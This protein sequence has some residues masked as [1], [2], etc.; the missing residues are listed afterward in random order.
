MFFRA[1]LRLTAWY[2]G[3]I[4]VVLVVLGGAAYL[5]LRHELDAEIHQSL[6]DATALVQAS[7]PTAPSDSVVLSG[8]DDDSADRHEGRNGDDDH[9]REAGARQLPTDV[10]TIWLN[11][12]GSVVSNPRQIDT[13]GFPLAELAATALESP[14]EDLRVGDVHYR[15]H[16]S[17]ASVTRDSV[18]V[19]GRSLA[20]RDRQLRALTLVL[21]L[22]GVGAVLL[23]G[24]GG[25]WIAGR[26]LSPIRNALETQR[27]FVS[28]ASH[29]LRTPVAVVRAN[30]EV[31]LR[32]PDENIE[33]NI[34]H[35][36]AI[37]DES[38]HMSRLVA[39][40][41]TLARADEERLELA[42]E[43]VELDV[44]LAAVT[45]DMSA[46]A[47][48]RGV[49]LE[50]SLHSAQ[51]VGDRQRLRQVAAILI[52]NAIKYTP[53]G[54]KVT[55]ACRRDG[56]RVEFTVTDT[57][58]GIAPEDRRHIFERFYRADRARTGGSGSGLGLAIAK[59]IVDAHDGQI[60]VD[61]LPGTGTAFTV[62]LAGT[63]HSRVA[64][65]VQPDS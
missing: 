45:R 55:V 15:I 38:E 57:G 7:A 41:L 42:R 25:W 32:H 26:T 56:H 61:S 23:A 37:S 17:A 11:N 50:S 20:A 9:P 63:R 19:V 34:D 10:F 22:G 60:T 48:V 52:D 29:E 3:A 16:V 2:M 6:E 12:D 39:D 47:E 64:P 13:S 40:L 33:A 14:I 51:T 5:I 49:T 8:N 54:G 65:G 36:A 27:Q 28:D 53:E 1:R 30:A 58:P 43:P 59:S 24:S 35:V 21:A 62:R 18:V 44:V 46:V 31:L 4:L